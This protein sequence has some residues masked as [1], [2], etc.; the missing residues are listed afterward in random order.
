[1]EG[2]LTRVERIAESS[3]GMSGDALVALESLLSGLEELRVLDTELRVQNENLRGARAELEEEHARYV[4][5][6]ELAPDA[7][8]VSDGVGRILEVNASAGTL[9]GRRAQ[10]LIGKPLASLLA[11]DSRIPFRTACSRLEAG[12]APEALELR[13]ATRS[14][15]TSAVLVEATAGV[16]RRRDGAFVLRWI[17]RDVTAQRQASAEV[18]LLAEELEARVAERTQELEETNEQLAAEQE[19]A[20]ADR[21]RLARLLERLPEA[22]ITVSAAHEIVFANAAATALLGQQAQTGGRLPGEWYGLDL[23]ALVGE[24][25]RPR[26]EGVDVSVTSADGDRVY[27][28]LGVPAEPPEGPV[29]V[30][31]DASARAR[32]ERAQREFVTNAAH[33]LLTPLTAIASA[34]EVLYSGAKDSPEERD[35]FLSHIDAQTHRLT[36]LSRALLVLARAQTQQEPPRVEV[37]PLEPLLRAAADAAPISEAVALELECQPRLAAVVN[38]DLTEQVVWNLLSNAARYTSQGRI[39]VTAHA[40]DGVV[41]VEIADTGPGM[42]PD[43]RERV[44]ERFFSASEDGRGFGLGLAIAMQAVEALGGRLDIDSAVGV[45]TTARVTLP[46]AELVDP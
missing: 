46:A 26:A 11:L 4:E 30:I 9:F 23:E 3:D 31:V 27:R 17:L 22:V 5:L 14:G 36:R 45:G 19:R 21:A 25:A 32:I 34:I 37:V 16:S 28:V 6:F 13:L 42:A 44:T 35:L 38:R 39:R 41:V 40:Y 7:Y 1:V 8:V 24:L 20:S 10:Y 2:L 15:R 33:E 12:A 43:V 29:L 18:R